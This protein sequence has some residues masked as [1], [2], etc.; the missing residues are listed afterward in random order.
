M[1]QVDY[2]QFMSKA[3]FEKSLN[4]LLGLIEGIRADQEVSQAEVDELRNWLS[5]NEYRSTY[6]FKEII[7]IIEQALSDGV[8]TIDEV[9]D[10]SWVCQNY[11]EINPYYDA[12]TTDLHILQ[13]IIHG[14]LS[15]NKI[16]YSELSY[17][18]E[19]LND[20][21]HLESMFPYDEIY[22]LLHTVMKDG[23]LDLNETLLLKAFFSDFIDTSI[24][25]NIHSGEMEQLKNQ[26]NISGIC[27]LGP[28]IEFDGKLFCFTGEST[29]MTRSE[30]EKVI[31]S[32]GGFFNK[33]ITKKTNYLI[34]GSGGNPCWAFS[35]YGRKI[36]QA[37][38]LRKQGMN[39]IIAHEIDFWDALG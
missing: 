21:D 19:W 18:K 36:E 29:R 33:G 3:N 16:E 32:K 4:S 27:A 5:L 9:E 10:I 12:I 25:Y 7:P 34:V 24:S 31:L 26:M 17:L 30:I 1:S 37:I 8:V 11:L 20:H 15:D 28:N 35:C 14:I 38:K 39:V 23:M 6:P 2:S 13:G 22:S